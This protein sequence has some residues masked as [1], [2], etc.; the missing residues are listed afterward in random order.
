MNTARICMFGLKSL[1]TSDTLL[2]LSIVNCQ[3]KKQFHVEEKESGACC[4]H[5]SLC[6]VHS[7]SCD[8]MLILSLL[9]SPVDMEGGKERRVAWKVL[10]TKGVC[11][12][13]SSFHK[14]QYGKILRVFDCV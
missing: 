6:F 5:N 10:E 4:R 8:L 1:E 9:L 14:W 11:F 13:Y 12:S 2:S 7:C 3:V